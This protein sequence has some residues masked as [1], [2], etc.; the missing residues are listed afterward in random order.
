MPTPTGPGQSPRTCSFSNTTPGLLSG[1]HKVVGAPAGNDRLQPDQRNLIVLT[2]GDGE[3][4]GR[5]RPEPSLAP[6]HQPSAPNPAAT[7]GVAA[8]L[9]ATATEVVVVV[10]AVVVGRWSGAESR[11]C[12]LPKCCVG[13]RRCPRDGGRCV[14]V[15]PP[16]VV[17]VAPGVVV[18]EEFPFRSSPAHEENDR[19]PREP[20]TDRQDPGGAVH[21]ASYPEASFL[22]GRQS[23]DTPEA[24]TKDGRAGESA[25]RSP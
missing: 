1:S 4:R 19:S 7:I 14:V 23:A 20:R 13:G 12:R 8:Q 9:P 16:G 3:C 10:G 11:R 24:A 2:T 6:S 22:N 21:A 15:R 18:V 25:D 17:V 5:H